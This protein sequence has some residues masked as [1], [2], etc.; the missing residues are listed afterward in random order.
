MSVGLI[1]KNALSDGVKFTLSDG[2]E[3]KLSGQEST[4]LK[5]LPTLKNLKPEIIQMLSR[6]AKWWQTKSRTGE[7]SRTYFNPSVNLSYLLTRDSNTIEASPVSEPVSLTREC[8]TC[9]HTTGRN[10][11]GKPVEAGLSPLDG[12]IVYHPAAGAGCTA[13][14]AP[15]DP[16]LLAL[17]DQAVQ[18]FGFSGDDVEILRGMAT[19]DPAGLKVAIAGFRDFPSIRLIGGEQR[20]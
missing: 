2:G 1:L 8:S 18:R 5:W 14:A 3:L 10:S 16:D 13:W 19:S 20:T 7:V 9:T 15:I 11:C 12:V 4:V 6:Q 17:I